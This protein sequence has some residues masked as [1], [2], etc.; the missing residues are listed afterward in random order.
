[1]RGGGAEGADK[2]QVALGH[3]RDWLLYSCKHALHCL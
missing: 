2:K 1:M 3:F